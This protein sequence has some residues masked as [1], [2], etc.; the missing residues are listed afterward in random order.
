MEG[1]PGLNEKKPNFVEETEHERHHERPK[2]S[3][4]ARGVE[5]P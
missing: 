2:Q 3:K 1:C 5:I 4:E